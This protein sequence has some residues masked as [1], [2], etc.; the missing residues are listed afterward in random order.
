MPSRRSLGDFVLDKYEVLYK[1]G[2][3]QSTTWSPLKALV[4]FQ[5]SWTFLNSRSGR[6][7]EC[8]TVKMEVN[9]IYSYF[10]I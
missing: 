2:F 1:K 3:H 8:E 6:E 7:R 9:K 5:T 10:S 4:Y